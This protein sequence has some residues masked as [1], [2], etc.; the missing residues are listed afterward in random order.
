MIIAVTHE[1]R[2]VRSGSYLEFRLLAKFEGKPST[3][4]RVKG[5]K[6]SAFKSPYDATAFRNKLVLDRSKT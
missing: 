3:T 1:F 2:K 5:V 6:Y 4:F